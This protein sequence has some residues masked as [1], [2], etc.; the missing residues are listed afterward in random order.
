M[1]GVTIFPT[2]YALILSFFRWE[3]IL[4]GR[5]FVGLSNYIGIF[6][7]T[8]YWAAIGHTL[9][10]V[11]GAV[12]LEFAL[13]FLLANTLVEEI[14]GKR[15]FITFLILPVM[16]LPVVSGYTWRLLLDAQYGPINPIIGF[17]IGKPYFQFPWLSFTRTAYLGIIITDVWEWT[18]FA[19][20]V[21]LAGLT[22]L[23]TDVYEASTID[24]ASPW[25]QFRYITLPLL[26]S[27]I[28]VV[29]LFRGLECFKLF[30]IIF[31]LTRGG[32][33]KTTETI[34]LY[35]YKIGFQYFRMGYT[36][37]GA[38]ILMLLVFGVVALALVRVVEKQK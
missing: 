34:S 27:I 29:L 5:P 15:Y 36:A 24:G 28:I 25:Q 7:D 37:A 38:I 9:L 26:K 35:I 6:R 23:P 33:G 2:F 10:I 11:A 19:F 22:S 17:L 21:L 32:P 1:L 3:Y 16:V 4:P 20:L 12:S 13:G 31:G 18:P 30:D 14:K 8:R